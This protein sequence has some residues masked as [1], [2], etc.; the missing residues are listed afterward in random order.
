MKKYFKLLRGLGSSCEDFVRDLAYSQERKLAPIQSS[1]DDIYLVS[2]PKSGAT[3]MD[4]LIAN[5]NIA[6]SGVDRNVTFYNIHQYVPDIHD[7]RSLSA[8]LLS[9]PGFRFIKSHS[10]LNRYYNNVIYIVRN[11]EDTMISYYNFLQGLGHF[12]GT[13]S[14]LI[15]SKRFGIQAWVN[16]VENWLFHS[17]ASLAFMMV[18]YEDLKIDP[19]FEVNRIYSHL[20]FSLPQTILSI[21]C[22]P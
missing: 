13:L 4:F 22:M 1:N 3:W 2:F 8:P 7:S 17:P 18:R 16:H 12:N 15:E 14:N 11:P 21:Q 9:F 19:L 5:I 6:M 10:G 20:G